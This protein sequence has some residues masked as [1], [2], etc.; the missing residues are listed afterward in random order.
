M[1][2][3]HVEAFMNEKKNENYAKILFI[4]IFHLID[5]IKWNESYAN[6]TLIKALTQFSMKVK[7][8]QYEENF[9]LKRCQHKRPIKYFLYA[10][11]RE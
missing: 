3:L 6:D 5:I 1:Q 10:L 8:Q 11:K 2:Q 4:V 9:A 7:L